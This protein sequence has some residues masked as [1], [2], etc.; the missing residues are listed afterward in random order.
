VYYLD[1]D[2]GSVSKEKAVIIGKAYDDNGKLILDCFLKTTGKKI[3]SATV[4]DSALG[5]L[6]GPFKTYHPDMKI[7]SFGNY[8]ENDMDGVWKYWD[9]AGLLT[10]SV[11]YAKGIRTAY[12]KYE[13]HFGEPTIG[14]VLF[15]E[16][17]KNASYFYVYRFTDSLR[18]SF[19]DR[20][21]SVNKGKA[22][23]EFEAFFIGNRGLYK[24]YDSTGLVSSD[25]VF[26]REIIEAEFPGG[27]AAWRNFLETNLNRDVVTDNNAP[28]G[29]Y[30]VIMRFIVNQDGSLDDIRAEMDPG[31]GLVKE[32]TR[33]L[34][35]SPK[36]K[37]AILYGK[38]KRA[39]RRQPIT[40]AI[41][42]GD[43]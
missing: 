13:Y 37:P 12:A 29:K 5:M 39:Y 30:T 7:E 19:T 20:H 3:I 4:S 43:D 32:A 1:K 6:H 23:T 10:D 36:W 40:V 9:E 24:Q 25:S 2:L 31:Y 17:L 11:I 21:V 22:K 26:T 35:R 34:K 33:V 27:D 42:H 15:P 38:F 14:K 16:A 41:D 18:N 28:T 8:F